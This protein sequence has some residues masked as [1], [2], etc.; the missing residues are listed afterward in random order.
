MTRWLVT[1][2]DWLAAALLSLGLAVA[3]LSRCIG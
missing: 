1:N 2:R 3:W